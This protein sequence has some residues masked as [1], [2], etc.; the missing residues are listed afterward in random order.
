MK[1]IALLLGSY[2]SFVAGFEGAYESFRNDPIETFNFEPNSKTVLISLR[3]SQVTL[4]AAYNQDQ[5]KVSLTLGRMDL[6]YLKQKF[7][8]LV[9]DSTFDDVILLSNANSIIVKYKDGITKLYSGS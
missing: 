9:D 3:D 1:Y 2:L 4:K 6:E 5:Q 8:D 7:P